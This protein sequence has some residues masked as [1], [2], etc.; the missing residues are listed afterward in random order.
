MAL[1]VYLYNNT[2]R[3]KSTK[4]AP[5]HTRVL[6]C[7]LK[8][9]TSL[10][11]PIIRIKDTSKP[12][13]NYF[14]ILDRYYWVVNVTSLTSDLWEITGEVDPLTTFRSSILG[15]P[16]FV[17]YDSTPN[18][19][20]PDTRLAVKTDCDVYTATANMPW[21]FAAG[22]GT[23]LIATTG[24]STELNW[25]DYT[26]TPD[27]KAG[28]GVY[29][30]PLS[31]MNQLGFNISD[32][33]TSLKRYGT[34]YAS[35]L[36][37][38]MVLFNPAIAS[39][40]FEYIGNCVS[41]MGQILKSFADLG[42]NTWKLLAS[43]TIGGGNALSNIKASYWLPFDLPG[44]AVQSES[45]PLALGTY[46]DYV[47]G[48]AKVIDPI[49]TSLWIDVPIP[50]HYTDWRNVSCTEVM[51]YIPMIGCINIP[52]EVV[53]GNNTLQVR[54]AL[55]IYS[56]SMAA[57]VRC[58]GAEIGTYGANVGM[59]YMIGSSNMNVGAIANTITNAAAQ[60]YLGAAGSVVQS[61]VGMP[62]SVGGIGGGAGT[63]LTSN[64][65]CICRCHD[66]SQEPSALISTIGTPTHQLKTL[67]TSL[68]Y[69][70]CL[71]AQVVPTSDNN[72]P[73]ATKQ[74]LDMINSALNSGIYLE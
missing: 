19:Q 51:L 36:A 27:A 61:L 38:I 72:A 62:T 66:T 45:R 70:Q 65:V 30:I 35:E 1:S 74:E 11:N 32:L 22:D 6:D 31:S 58:D 24:C 49:I 60:N 57:E 8:D 9:N 54:I 71:N 40:F 23:Y 2:K 56:G 14:K 69:V 67:S 59:P 47:S 18:T 68:G 12:T 3:L 41:G 42:Y 52:S 13:E 4:E 7:V 21:N 34:N 15:T 5:Q 53:K 64:I 73:F 16:A 44:T 20:L 37:N 26:T 63:G 46:T 39:D 50:W 48:L 55:N 17:L 25:D 29:S 28:T 10:L 33:T 43:N